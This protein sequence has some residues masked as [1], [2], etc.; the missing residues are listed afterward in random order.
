MVQANLSSGGKEVCTGLVVFGKMGI[1]NCCLCYQME[2]MDIIAA[3]T[4]PS[5]LEARCLDNC[6]CRAYAFFTNVSQTSCEIWSEEM[7]FTENNN[8]ES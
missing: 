8:E 5:V 2:G 3:G 7:R 4:K 6:S 1:L